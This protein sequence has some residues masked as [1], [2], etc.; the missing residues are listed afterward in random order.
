MGLRGWASRWWGPKVGPSRLIVGLGNPGAEYAGNRHNV[1]FWCVDHL[2]ERHRL[3]FNAKRARSIVARGRL[4]GHDVALAK[5]QTYMN[6]SG[7]AVKQLLMGWGVPTHSL[8]VVYDDVDLPPGSL[9][10]RERGGAGTHNG[11][12]SVVESL[13]TTEFPRLR[14]GIGAPPPNRDIADYVLE[15][16]SSDELPRLREAVERSAEAIEL[17]IRRGA[18]AAMNRYN[19]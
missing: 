2:G 1:G 4:A 11:M 3:R 7:L 19:Q 14:I 15:D 9:R 16:P 12:R 18:G 10:L 13:G 5:P 8:L 6:L 17:F